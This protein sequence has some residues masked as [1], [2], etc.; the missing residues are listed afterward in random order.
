[1]SNDESISLQ[2]IKQEINLALDEMLAHQPEIVARYLQ[3][4]DNRRGKLIRPRLVIAFA[5]IFGCPNTKEL[6]L[7]AACCELLHIA[8]LIH[9][10]VIDQADS[11]RGK[12]TLRA[13]FG[14]ELAITV[15]DYLLT[16][17]IENLMNYKD[18][19]ILRLVN[20]ASQ[21]LVLGVINELSN[22][23]NFQLSIN[24][25]KRII[26]LKTGALMAL[27]CQIGTA[28]GELSTTKDRELAFGYGKHF[29]MAFQL[30]DD[31]LD[32]CVEPAL[33]G[34]PRFGDLREGRITM[35][36]IDALQKDFNNVQ[37]LIIQVQSS[38]TEEPAQELYELLISLGSI[39]Q[40]IKE[41]EYQL[42]LARQFLFKIDYHILTP[43]KAKPLQDIEDRLYDLLPSE[44]LTLG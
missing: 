32:V 43:E 7:V 20:K 40:T 12:P 34:K 3:A 13:Q 19:N 17:V 30:I 42:H 29:G 21:E 2:N 41:A 26:Y 14:N 6:F 11:R 5:N 31:L 37:D 33:S 18:F 36:I 38:E 10:D 24:E 4:L 44:I 27:C 16:I 35:P 15:G 28:L 39:H 25:F 22:K 8:T 9:D 23:N 1:M